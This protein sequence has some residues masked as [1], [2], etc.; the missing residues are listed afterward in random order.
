PAKQ[1]A[2][3][4]L[5]PY[6]FATMESTRQVLKV[7]EQVAP[8]SQPA[9]YEENLWGCPGGAAYTGWDHVGICYTPGFEGM[10]FG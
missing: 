2:P 10:P 4:Q 8:G 1:E 9:I 7:I 5:S 3:V 6:A